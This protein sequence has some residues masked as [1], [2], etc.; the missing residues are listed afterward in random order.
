MLRTWQIQEAKNKFSQVVDEAVN[1]GPQ[2]ITKHGIETAVV[3]SYA[4]YRRHYSDRK[5]LTHFLRESPL[6][7]Y[8]LDLSRDTSPPRDEEVS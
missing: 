8:N 3:I 2:I 6:A 4:D 1:D 5:K 7:G